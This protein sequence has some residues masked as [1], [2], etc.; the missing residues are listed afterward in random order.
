MTPVRGRLAPTPSGYLHLGNAYNLVLNW[1]WVRSQAGLMRLRIDDL[2]AARSRTEYLDDVFQTLDWLGLDWDEGPSSVGEHLR[3]HSQA[4]RSER[5][6]ALLLDLKERG[7]LFACRCSRK[8]IRA[9]DPEGRYPGTCRDLDL[10]W[11]QSDLAWRIKTIPHAKSEWLDGRLGPCKLEVHVVMP[12]F[13]VRRKDGL[14]AYQVASLSDDWDQG[15]NLIVRGEDLMYSTAA[16]LFLAQ[17]L[18][19]AWQAEV[20][21]FHH[22][23]IPDEAGKKLSKSAGSASMQS[24]RKHKPGAE[25]FYHWFAQQMGWP[26]KVSTAQEAL[27]YFVESQA[28]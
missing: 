20:K 26:A 17:A 11:E 1:L 7:A 19:R 3:S 6:Q 13:V 18:G 22:P 14:A 15:I 10:P 24:W 9:L 23:L 21:F 2:D 8:E 12:D 25:T 28:G 27:G 16:Q 5:Y 4:L